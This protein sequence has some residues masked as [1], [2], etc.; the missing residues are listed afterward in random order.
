MILST[1]TQAFFHWAPYCTATVDDPDV[2]SVIEEVAS[3]HKEE[4]SVA[5][6]SGNKRLVIVTA[7][8]IW[9]ADHRHCT[10]AAF[11]ACAEVAA[12]L[13]DG[14]LFPS[15]GTGSTAN[16]GGGGAS[17]PL[18]SPLVFLLQNNP[19]M[20]LSERDAFLSDLHEVQRAALEDGGG[21]GGGGEG[22]G[23]DRQGVD[24]E[25]F[26]VHDKTSLYER[27][28]CYRIGEEVHYREPVKL[29]EG[30][31]LWDLLALVARGGD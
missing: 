25:V 12:R 18:P 17:P 9:D 22:G 29:V 5:Q 6:G 20:P 4:E 15:V 2:A 3:Q 16:G 26:L 10:E 13:A 21:G 14:E 31:M 11:N 7:F 19:F 27:M 1:E 30:K 24:A 23:G 8:G 28:P